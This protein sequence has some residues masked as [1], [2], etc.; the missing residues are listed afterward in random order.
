MD[1]N[2]LL[3][4]R[5]TMVPKG[6]NKQRI[7]LADLPQLTSHLFA[8]VSPTFVSSVATLVPIC[9]EQWHIRANSY[10]L[11]EQQQP[12]DKETGMQRNFRSLNLHPPVRNLG[13][14]SCTRFNRL[15][16]GTARVAATMQESGLAHLHSM[17][18]GQ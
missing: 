4:T 16:T 8:V 14:E 6:A 11:T 18:A 1:E 2:N 12:W 9:D 13:Y 5:V 7:L 15:P 3:H 10:V 17:T